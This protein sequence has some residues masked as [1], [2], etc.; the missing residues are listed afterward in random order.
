MLCERWPGIAPRA[1]P[2]ATPTSAKLKMAE[3][4]L[5]VRCSAYCST[6]TAVGSVISRLFIGRRTAGLEGNRSLLTAS[7]LVLIPLLRITGTVGVTQPREFRR[8]EIVRRQILVR[9]GVPIAAALAL[10]GGAG[11]AIYAA[12]SGSSGQTTVV[13][14]V[15]AQP[16][17]TRATSTTL[18]QLYKN[19]APGVV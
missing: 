19:V 15:P 3:A 11:A 1:A 16:A 5:P 8:A 7:S 13:A 9:R 17:A 2:P 10:G 18:T 6:M 12:S 14:S 4:A